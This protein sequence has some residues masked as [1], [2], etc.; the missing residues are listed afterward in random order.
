MFLKMLGIGMVF[1][2]SVIAGYSMSREYLQRLRTLEQF[3]KMLL[4]L[5]GEI[6]YNNSGISE[7][8]GKVSERLDNRIGDFLKCVCRGFEKGKY[9]LKE[10]WDKAG[11]EILERGA[12]LK[13]ED[14]FLIKELGINLGITDR[15]TQINNILNYMEEIDMKIKELNEEKGE[16]CRLYR[17]LGVMAGAFMAIVLV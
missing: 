9:T 11:S 15:E 13:K 6:K 16:K 2:A 12:G 5:K 10:I 17:T 3:Y 4:L 8:V 1:S 7:A 14:I